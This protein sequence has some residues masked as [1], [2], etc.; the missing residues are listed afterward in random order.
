[1]CDCHGLFSPSH[2]YLPTYINIFT[3]TWSVFPISASRSGAGCVVVVGR[4]VIVIGFVAIVVGVVGSVTAPLEN[5]AGIDIFG[6]Q[7]IICS[8]SWYTG[9]TYSMNCYIYISNV[10]P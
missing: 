9:T 7:H 1:M 8:V 10:L 6:F 3:V 5:G 4:V 2:V